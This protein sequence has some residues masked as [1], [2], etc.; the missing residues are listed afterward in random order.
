[1]TCLY[2]V[3]GDVEEDHAAAGQQAN[4][5]RYQQHSRFRFVAVVAAF[6]G[7][8]YL[9]PAGES[10]VNRRPG[11]TDCACIHYAS[12]HGPNIVVVHLPRRICVQNDLH[13]HD[14][15]HSPYAGWLDAAAAIVA[16]W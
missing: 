4:A 12:L 10:L 5:A 3:N 11:D 13:M 2:G 9:L 7:G 6:G 1:V 8:S 16:D 15:P 14:G